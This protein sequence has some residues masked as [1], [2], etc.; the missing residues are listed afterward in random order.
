MPWAKLRVVV[1]D[2]SVDDGDE[3]RRERGKRSL[4]WGWAATERF[5]TSVPVVRRLRMWKVLLR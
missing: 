3:G 5:V 1:D 4:L 2:V